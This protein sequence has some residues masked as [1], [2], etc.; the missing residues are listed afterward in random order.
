LLK[1]GSTGAATAIVVLSG[2]SSGN[3]QAKSSAVATTVASPIT[4]A[5]PAA[6]TPGASAAAATAQPKRGGTL[7]VAFSG[8]SATGAIGDLDPHTTTDP[9][10]A[11]FWGTISRG[12]F[13]ID[14]A[15]GGPVPDLAASYE[16]PDSTT[17]VIAL[18]TASWEN[19]APMNGR[20]LKADDIKFS[21]DRIRSN[22]PGFT[23]GTTIAALDRVEVADDAHVKL[24]LKQPSVSLLWG[25]AHNLNVIVPPEVVMQFGDLKNPASM[26][27]LGPFSIEAYDPTSAVTVARRN[28]S[29]LRDRPYLDKVRYL[30]ITDAAA[31]L[32]AY[33]SGQVQIVGVAADQ[34]DDFKKQ[35]PK[36]TLQ[37]VGSLI[38][39]TFTLR[40]DGK[41]PELTDLRVRQALN[42]AL[43]RAEA[44]QVFYGGRGKPI[45]TLPWV[46][47]P[48]ATPQDSLATYAGYSKNKDAERAQAKQ[49]LSAAGHSDLSLQ[50]LTANL[51]GAGAHAAIAQYVQDQLK[52]IGVNAKLDLQEYT[53]YKKM[54]DE[55]NW[56]TTV[57]PYSSGFNPDEHLRIYAYTGASRNYGKYSNSAFDKLVDAEDQEP[58]INKR[59]A[60][61]QQAQKILLDDVER[62]WIAAG[63]SSIASQP[64][65][66]GYKPDANYPYFYKWENVWL[67]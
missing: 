56:F 59:A 10:A 47:E 44:V 32:A 33:R 50:I 27:G 48:Y 39:P 22:Q 4:G 41:V 11:A 13:Q 15:K 49:L 55:G 64:E 26:V 29:W 51:Q 3:K 9:A 23:R 42:L 34:V 62:A 25:L 31:A 20:K 43:D 2:C 12:L 54:V 18:P 30:V 6:S 24:V 8:A 14:A 17:I 53:T 60:L 1:A 5:A 45:G 38:R 36:D 7:V 57:D 19:K 58:D 16:Q 46:L 37:Q 40:H 61:F 66:Q 65:V 67:S 21:L 52:R 35:R 28:D 63:S